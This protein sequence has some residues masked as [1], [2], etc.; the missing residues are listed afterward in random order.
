[1]ENN[2]VKILTKNDVLEI[3]QK[4][5]PTLTT[6]KSLIKK[7]IK[8]SG[9]ERIKGTLIAIVTK[10]EY[11]S[12]AIFIYLTIGGKKCHLNYYGD[13]WFFGQYDSS[14]DHAVEQIVLQ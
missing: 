2:K 12:N 6:I 1:M 9:I 5:F 8:L 7:T 13:G 14:G 3:L 11:R 10:I 4:Q